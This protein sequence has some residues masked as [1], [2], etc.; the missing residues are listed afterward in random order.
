MRVWRIATPLSLATLA[1]ACATASLGAPDAGAAPVQSPPV[2]AA[3]SPGE[4]WEPVSPAPSEQKPE[5]AKPQEP[6]PCGSASATTVAGVD[7][8]VADG[9][10]RAEL[11]SVS[12]SRDVAHV[13]ASSALASALASGNEAAVRAAVHKIVY[14]P[15]W[16]IV[17]LRVLQEGRVV[18]DVGGPYVIAPVTGSLQW[19]GKTVG[20]YV[21]SVQDDVGYVKLVTRYIGVPVDLYRDGSFLM[22]TLRP[23]PGSLHTGESVTVH[24]AAYQ[25]EL[26]NANAFPSGELTIALL[27]PRQADDSAAADCESLRIAAWGS[28]VKHLASRFH[29]LA[30][31]YQDL[32]DLLDGTTGGIAFVFSGSERIAGRAGPT[33]IPTRGSVAFEGRTWAV[34]S[35]SPQ[36]GVRI[37]F[38]TP[39]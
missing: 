9:I 21:M 11:Q 17:R 30:T 25:V 39:P 14:T 22:G 24:G 23:V 2:Q 6:P 15:H 1:V 18:A 3:G 26:L 32:V 33:Q 10:Y 27:I 37:Y 8:T 31:H 7:A 35:W 16:H 12:V 38:L 19:K 5:Q 29:P 20:T 34:F 4:L 13:T 36:P 28:I